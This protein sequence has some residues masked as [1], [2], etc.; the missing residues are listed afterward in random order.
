LNNHAR[1]FII[2]LT[3]SGLGGGIYLICDKSLLVVRPLM[4]IRA[5]GVRDVT[6]VH[7]GLNGHYWSRFGKVCA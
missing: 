4:G 1:F 5:V 3:V 6:L 7:P 2:G